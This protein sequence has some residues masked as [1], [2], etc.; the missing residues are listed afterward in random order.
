MTM[1]GTSKYDDLVELL[2]KSAPVLNN[3]DTVKENIMREIR[4]DKAGNRIR[5]TI[6]EFL[7]G[8]IYV[9]WMRRSL[10]TAAA[11]VILVFGYQQLLII[12]KIN[13]LA[14]HRIENSSAVMTSIS[15]DINSRLMYYRITGKNPSND[16]INVSEKEINKLI[17][18]INKLKLKY[19][20][21]LYMIE[22]DPQLKEYFE[23]RLNR[24]NN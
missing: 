3:A 7:F 2:K 21:L 23:T 13:N 9:G 15:D 17:I 14:D 10:V 4:R 16:K 6:E 22:N 8:W 19:E 24:D 11:V 5:S 1:N 20:D 12:R 18:E